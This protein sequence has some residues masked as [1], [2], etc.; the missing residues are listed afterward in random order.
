MITI[1]AKMH[2]NHISQNSSPGVCRVWLFLS[3]YA[4]SDRLPGNLLSNLIHWPDSAIVTTY[5]NGI[6]YSINPPLAV[7]LRMSS[8]GRLELTHFARSTGGI[9]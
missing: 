2:G 4:K 7:N 5:H 6:L 1:P 9:K 8:D 3:E